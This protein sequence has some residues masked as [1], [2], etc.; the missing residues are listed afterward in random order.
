MSKNNSS[1]QETQETLKD[2]DE[3]IKS[4]EYKTWVT[5]D[6]LLAQEGLIKSS[7]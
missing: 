5:L 1:W 3:A 4:G 2:A 6:E 7:K